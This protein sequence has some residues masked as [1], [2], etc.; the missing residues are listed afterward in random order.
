MDAFA[1]LWLWHVLGAG[2]GGRAQLS[3]ASSLG[4]PPRAL[5]PRLQAHAGV[6]VSCRTSS[7]K[8]APG[9]HGH[10]CGGNVVVREDKS[11]GQR[12]VTVT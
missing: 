9:P 1:L 2:L 12:Q 11:V 7:D 10:V 8:A 6:H 5:S 3:S 4:G